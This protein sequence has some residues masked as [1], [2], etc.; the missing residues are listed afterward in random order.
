MKSAQISATAGFWDTRFRKNLAKHKK[1]K[2]HMATQSVTDPDCGLFVKGDHKRQFGSGRSV[3]TLTFHDSSSIYVPE[4]QLPLN[5]QL[6]FS[7]G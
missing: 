1:E 5:G 6:G 7:T 3:F 4:T 2:T